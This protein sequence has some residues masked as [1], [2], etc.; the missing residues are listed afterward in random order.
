[1]L[2]VD[3]DVHHGNGTQ[4]M[5]YEDERVCFVSLHRHDR[6]SFYP[7]G[8]CGDMDRIGGYQNKRA[9]GTNVNIPWGG[10]ET[11]DRY[12]EQTKPTAGSIQEDREPLGRMPEA[13]PPLHKRNSSDDSSLVTS[14]ERKTRQF[15][16][17]V[18]DTG[19]TSLS[20]KSAGRMN[21]SDDFDEASKLGK[22]TATDDLRPKER[23]S[24][25]V[26]TPPLCPHVKYIQGN[27]PNGQSHSTFTSPSPPGG[28]EPLLGK[29]KFWVGFGA[30]NHTFSCCRNHT[31]FFRLGTAR[32]ANM[33]STVSR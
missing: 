5:F 14:R 30:Q 1:M 25:P 16:G 15:V 10:S 6:G 23:A 21:Q 19:Q 32:L 2:I 4:H 29:G 18:D 12:K 13:S 17:S 28:W 8:P 11:S 3:W 33:Y 31:F 22:A 27:Y 20:P 26:S 7:G 24:S 9:R